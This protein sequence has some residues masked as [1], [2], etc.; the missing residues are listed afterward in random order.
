MHPDLVVRHPSGVKILF[1]QLKP[2]KKLQPYP[3]DSFLDAIIFEEG[4][5]HVV[6][7]PSG[8]GKTSYCI[9]RFPDALIVS[10]MDDLAHYHDEGTIIFDDMCFTHMPRTAQI[11]I[12]DQELDRSIHIRYRTANIPAYTRKIFT[13]NVRG[14]FLDDP[15]INRRIKFH[16]VHNLINRD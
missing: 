9:A 6:Y 12:V 11:H 15:A 1:D 2:K 5:S 10:H 16:H 8:S 13:T 4:F 7:G 14:I 3:L